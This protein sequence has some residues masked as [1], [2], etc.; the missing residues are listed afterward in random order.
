MK[1]GKHNQNNPMYA[2]YK[3]TLRF[4]LIV[5]KEFPEFFS[6]MCLPIVEE[7]PEELGQQTRNIFL[8]AYPKDIKLPD[9]FDA[10]LMSKIDINDLK[11]LP[12]FYANYEEIIAKNN[13]HEALMN[14][15]NKDK[16]R[17]DSFRKIVT[18]FID[19]QNNTY[20]IQVV[21]AFILFVAIFNIKSNSDPNKQKE[22]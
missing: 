8:A 17:G 22:N 18:S 14:Y 15:I 20:N 19:I 5:L 6:A 9:P 12:Q 4:L 11:K 16:D 1:N 13:L 10:D 2:F 3:G 7:I 21:N